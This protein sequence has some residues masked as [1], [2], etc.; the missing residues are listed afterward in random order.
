MPVLVAGSV[1]SDVPRPSTSAD[2]FTLYVTLD[3]HFRGE[4]GRA[5]WYEGHNT[6]FFT[7]SRSTP[8]T[9]WR[10]KTGSAP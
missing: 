2:Q 3:L 8:E 1:Y 6:E 9:G 4:P 5:D 7:F 10:M